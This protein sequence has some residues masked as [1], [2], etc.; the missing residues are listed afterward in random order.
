MI[1]VVTS[2]GLFT[3]NVIRAL[4]PITHVTNPPGITFPEPGMFLSKV[5]YA[6]DANA[7]ET[8]L[9]VPL[10][11]SGNSALVQRGLEASLKAS[12]YPIFKDHAG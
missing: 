5:A 4:A 6:T 12:S 10:L 9:Y 1:K 7:P 11:T 3:A 2:S 8:L